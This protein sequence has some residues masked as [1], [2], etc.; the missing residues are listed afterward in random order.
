MSIYHKQRGMSALFVAVVSDNTEIATKIIDA[1]A[2]LDLQEEV[3]LP[4]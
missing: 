2:N 4:F 3:M 1:G